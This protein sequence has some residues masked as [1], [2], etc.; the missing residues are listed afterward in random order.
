MTVLFGSIVFHFTCLPGFVFHYSVDG[1]LG[2]HILSTVNTVAVNSG[3]KVVICVSLSF[4][5]FGCK[6][7]GGIAG[8][9]GNSVFGFLSKLARLFHS[10]CTIL[11]FYQ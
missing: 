6:P 3:I 4:S 8:L 10:G 9:Y 7:R 11:Y 1:Q 5:F 2:F